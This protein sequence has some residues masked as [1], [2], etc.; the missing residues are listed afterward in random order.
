MVNCKFHDHMAP[1]RY[2]LYMQHTL[3]SAY[4]HYVYHGVAP[5]VLAH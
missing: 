3:V 2:Y 5:V 4:Q 1:L